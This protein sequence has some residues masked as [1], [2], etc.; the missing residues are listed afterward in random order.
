MDVNARFVIV[1][2]KDLVFMVGNDKNTHES[3]DVGIWVNT[4]FFAGALRSMFEQAWK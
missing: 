3:S 2:G 4:P 1:D